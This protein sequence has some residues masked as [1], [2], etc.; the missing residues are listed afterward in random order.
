MNPLNKLAALFKG[1]D[2]RPNESFKDKS[3]HEWA[4]YKDELMPVIMFQL[5]KELEE[6]QAKVAVYTLTFDFIA[7]DGTACSECTLGEIFESRIRFKI[8]KMNLSD[9]YVMPGLIAEECNIPNH[10]IYSFIEKRLDELNLQRVFVPYCRKC[11]QWDFAK[12][13][14]TLIDVVGGDRPKCDG[15]GH[16]YSD[17]LGDWFVLYRKLRKDNGY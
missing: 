2:K 13:A 10:I 17:I 9:G 15:C 7:K 1:K 8:D 12:A 14:T 5:D 6:R 3:D 11:K 4:K 16:Q